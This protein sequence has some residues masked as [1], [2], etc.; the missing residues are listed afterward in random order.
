MDIIELGRELGKLIQK[1]ELYL[2]MREAKKSAD[3]DFDLQSLKNGLDLKKSEVEQESFKLFNSTLEDY[4]IEDIQKNLKRICDE[5]EVIRNKII[6]NENE[7]AYNKAVTAFNDSFK[8]VIAIIENS[9]N[10]DDPETTDFDPKRND[11]Q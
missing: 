1:D 11:S 8:R 10:G 3:S 5:Y 4:N 2:K 7:V 9:A 6:S